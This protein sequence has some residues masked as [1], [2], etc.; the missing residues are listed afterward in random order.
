MEQVRE[1]AAAELEK[2]D[3]D[4]F[5]LDVVCGTV[6][7]LLRLGHEEDARRVWWLFFRQLRFRGKLRLAIRSGWDLYRGWK[8]SHST[9]SA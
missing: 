7:E 4:T 3:K 2:L 1:Q 9:R 5:L 6:E 8:T